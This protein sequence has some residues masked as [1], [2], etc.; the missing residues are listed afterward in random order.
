MKTKNLKLNVAY[1]DMVHLNFVKVEFFLK[2]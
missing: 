1:V 2:K